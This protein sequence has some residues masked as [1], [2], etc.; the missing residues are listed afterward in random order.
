[1]GEIGHETT[2]KHKQ[3]ENHVY[4]FQRIVQYPLL[5]EYLTGF[6]G[7]RSSMLHWLK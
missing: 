3:N 7:E 6:A 5:H 4:V 1:M 2:T